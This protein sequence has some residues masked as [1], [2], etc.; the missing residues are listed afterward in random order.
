MRIEKIK[1]GVIQEW[2]KMLHQEHQELRELAKAEAS[3]DERYILI[4][5]LE[6]QYEQLPKQIWLEGKDVIENEYY[7]KTVGVE[8]RSW[9]VPYE[10]ERILLGKLAQMK[11][12][13]ELSKYSFEELVSLL[14][15]W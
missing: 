12:T 13:G 6:K 10:E 14:K 1:E 11:G 4:E 9:Y 8:D 3:F 5:E 7:K 2:R 15:Y